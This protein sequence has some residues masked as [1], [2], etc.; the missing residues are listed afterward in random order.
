MDSLVEQ[1]SSFLLGGRAWT[2]DRVSHE[3][4]EIVVREAPRGVKPA[5]GG[6]IPQ[7]LGFEV[8]QRM[9]RAL[10]EGV[11][12]PY[13]DDAAAKHLVEKRADLGDLL[14]REG[15]AVQ[16]DGGIARWWTFAG[17]RINHTVKYAFEVL[18]G[19]KAVADNFQL[20]TEGDAVTHES[21]RSAI[22]RMASA[23][24]WEE[25]ATRKAILARLPGYRLSK[26]QDCLPEPFALEVIEN[27]L[28]DVEGTVRWL[29]GLG[30]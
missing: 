23:S 15:P 24:F 26:F 1:M 17:G 8:C 19:W 27:H 28:L 21:V 13:L 10:I 14:R 5:W 2:V 20:R 7:H 3:D 6:F 12:Y 22:R 9:R 29:G 25:P 4:R 30:A 11:R 18:E 16:L